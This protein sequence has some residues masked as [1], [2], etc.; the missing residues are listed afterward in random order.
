MK[1]LNLDKLLLKISE[2]I[3]GKRHTYFKRVNE[4]ADKYSKI[5][6]GEDIG[7]LLIRFQPTEDEDQFKTRVQLTKTIVS[8][9]V[10]KIKAPFERVSR[11]NN[12][13]SEIVFKDEQKENGI[14]KLNN[15]LDDFWGEE[16]LQDYMEDRFLDLSFI[17]PNAFISTEIDEEGSIYPFEIRSENALN[18]H[19]ENNVLLYLIYGSDDLDKYTLYHKEYIINFELRK[20]K[21]TETTTFKSDVPKESDQAFIKINGNVFTYYVIENESEK[22]PLIQ[23]GYKRDSYT[24]GNTYVNPFHSGLNRLEKIIKSDSELDITIAK[25]TFPQKLQY[26]QKCQGDRKNHSQCDDGIDRKT[27]QACVK[28]KGTGVMFH[29]SAQDALIYRLPTK[30]ERADGQ[31][32]MDLDKLM[33]YKHPPIDLIKFQ[34]EYL[35]QLEDEVI[36]DV[37]TS[38]NFERSNGTATATEIG[39]NMESIYDTLY[40]YARKFS[41]IY[42]KI[43]KTSAD[44]LSLDGLKIVHYF[45]KDFKL[46]TTEQLLGELKAAEDANA[47]EF[48]KK[49]LAIDIAEKIYHDNPSALNKFKIKMQHAPF[50]GKTKEEVKDIVQTGASTD[51]NIVLYIEFENIFQALEDK[52]FAEA[53]PKD[54]YSLSYFEQKELIREEVERIRTIKA[55]ESNPASFGFDE[56][57]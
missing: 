8:A 13:T 1:D 15:L 40:P 31:Q 7:S 10:G 37:F 57:E 20:E 23:V 53:T 51:F 21:K 28:C 25:H 12:V 6:T 11:S 52:L 5:T 42:K 14:D 4:L 45:P 44:Y 3:A 33:V 29:R 17:D 56:E 54:F 30:S 16:S 41:K 27:S 43:I 2:T 49:Q 34:N 48:L 24:Y 50:S 18:Y 32:P 9:V 38:Q 46:K 35:K 36:K 47:P 39:Y 22:I 55:N 26:Y 19:Y